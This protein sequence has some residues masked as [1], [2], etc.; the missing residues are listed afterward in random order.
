MSGVFKYRKK[1][2]PVSDAR[3][4]YLAE[5]KRQRDARLVNCQIND[6][7]LRDWWNVLKEFDYTCVY[8]GKTRTRSGRR[9]RLTRDHIVPL[10]KGGDNT[11]SNIVPACRSCNSSKGSL[12]LEEWF[13]GNI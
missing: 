9:V 6:F 8:C 10:I 7:T 3:K 5:R 12:S 2:G 11:R 13:G 1:R 4:K